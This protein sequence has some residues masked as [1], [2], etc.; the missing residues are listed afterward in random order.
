MPPPLKEK[1]NVFALASGARAIAMTIA[2][3]AFKLIST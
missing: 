1:P 2:D 3:T